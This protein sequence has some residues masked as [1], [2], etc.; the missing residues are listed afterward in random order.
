[1]TPSGSNPHSS[2]KTGWNTYHPWLLTLS[3]VLSVILLVIGIISWM[4]A[5]EILGAPPSEQNE[6]IVPGL[7]GILF[8]V[9]A[10]RQLYLRGQLKSQ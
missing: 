2:R 10:G 8:F 9:V 6:P 7:L 4:P 5:P 3:G 1:M